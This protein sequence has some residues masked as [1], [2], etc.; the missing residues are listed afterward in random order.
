MK[1]FCGKF[2]PYTVFPL[3]VNIKSRDAQKNN[4]EN[5]CYCMIKDMQQ[6]MIFR[7]HLNF[8]LFG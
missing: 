6:L 2:S 5:I 4:K 1:M 3:H 8:L 7:W